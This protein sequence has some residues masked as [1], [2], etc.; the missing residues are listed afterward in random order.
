MTQWRFCEPTAACQNE[1]RP[2]TH[3][4]PPVSAQINPNTSQSSTAATACH[5]WREANCL[6]NLNKGVCND[7]VDYKNLKTDFLYVTRP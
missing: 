7:G 2:K 6:N 4:A 1:G 5:F 3:P